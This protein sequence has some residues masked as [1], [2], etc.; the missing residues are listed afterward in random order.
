MKFLRYRQDGRICEGVL[1]GE[2]IQPISG[3]FFG[4]FQL[5]DEQ[6]SLAEVEILP[7]CQP[8][9]IL[10]VGLNYRDH[11]QEIGLDLPKWPV[12]FTKAPT[13]VIGTGEG[14]V[15][16]EY[17]VTKLD[18]E[19]ELAV[20]IKKTAKNVSESDALDFCLGFTCANDVTARNLQP[21]DGQWV[22]AKSFDTFLP[23]G[24][25]IATDLDAGNLDIVCRLNGEIRQSS[26]TRHL[27]FPVPY[28]VSY[29]SKVMTLLPGDVIITG[30]P[31]GIGPM[32]P[33]DLVT[34]SISGIGDLTNPVVSAG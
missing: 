20:V 11:A 4:D 32:Q 23:L 10:C 30:T 31:A 8:G 21:K 16:P 12:I 14:I 18:Y 27:I 26:N 15:Y 22:V 1:S 17:F 19:G 6:I 25:V 3:S 24:P 33:G 28:L 5:L 34:V 9:K 13:S 7:P 29:L 2:T